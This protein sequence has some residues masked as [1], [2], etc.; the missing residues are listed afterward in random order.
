MIKLKKM[1]VI[2]LLLSFLLPMQALAT[3]SSSFSVVGVSELRQNITTGDIQ[4]KGH[5]GGAVN[6]A[7]IKSSDAGNTL[8]IGSDG[9]LYSTGGGGVTHPFATIGST[10]PAVTIGN[11]GT[12]SNQA[13]DFTI[14]SSTEAVF[15]LSSYADQSETDA[16]ATGARAITPIRLRNT[17]AM[18]PMGNA[19]AE[20]ITQSDTG[21]TTGS[22]LFIDNNGTVTEDNPFYFWNNAL[23]RLAVGHNVPLATHHIKGT[24]ILEHTLPIQYIKNSGKVMTDPTFN[25]QIRL[26]DNT[27]TVGGLAAILGFSGSANNRL[28]VTNRIPATV[29]LDNGISIFAGTSP[30]GINVNG[31]S[32]TNPNYV[33]F[34]LA[35]ASEQ[36]HVAGNILASGT[37]TPSDIRYKK[38][39]EVIEGSLDKILAYEPIIFNWD[40]SK[41]KIEDERVEKI[42]VLDKEGNVVG[43]R[44]KVIP[45]KHFIED[46]GLRKISLSAQS[47]Y[48]VSPD[49]TRIHNIAGKEV[50]T[51]DN[52]ALIADLVGAVQELN[53]KI[54]LLEAR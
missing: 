19:I 52:Q 42:D 1:Q 49:S 13:L 46:D 23:N 14:G 24:S 51:I 12:A 25:S 28:L 18:S 30:V 44:N 3:T 2:S 40:D 32:D 47:V 53:E 54:T 15:G 9:G 8:T 38:D 17:A 20:E 22:V 10:T 21:L 31:T 7:I 37:I 43:T 45:S 29:G 39:I 4:H 48:K 35:T 27:S 16:A 50:I 34:G 41:T 36:V 11:A 6:T 33:A 5:Y 26:T